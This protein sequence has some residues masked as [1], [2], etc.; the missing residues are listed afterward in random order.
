MEMQNLVGKINTLLEPISEEITMATELT[1]NGIVINTALLTAL[2]TTK[3]H[4]MCKTVA[5]E[6]REGGEFSK[7]E[8]KNAMFNIFQKWFTEYELKVYHMEKG[9]DERT[10]ELL[11]L[12]DA[13]DFIEA[14][15]E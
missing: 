15:F 14:M 2:K 13:K 8:E 6:F 12:S 3:F 5:K 10:C 4:L 9:S 1:P 11:F 7:V